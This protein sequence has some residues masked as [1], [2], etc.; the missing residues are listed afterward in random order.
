MLSVLF[1][2]YYHIIGLQLKEFRTQTNGSNATPWINDYYEK[3]LWV[4]TILEYRN[5][6]MYITEALPDEIIYPSGEDLD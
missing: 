3:Q 1:I 5:T 2:F 4:D 6:I